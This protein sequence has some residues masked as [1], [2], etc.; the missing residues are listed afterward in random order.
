MSSFMT[1][2]PNQLADVICC[3]Q[4]PDSFRI[5]SGW[6][7]TTRTYSKPIVRSVV[8]TKALKTMLRNND[9]RHNG[10]MNKHEKTKYEYR[11]ITKIVNTLI[12]TRRFVRRSVF[13][14]ACICFVVPGR[15]DFDTS[16]QQFPDSSG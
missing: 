1:F 11:N 8:K 4:V 13:G 2:D 10:K 16:Q 3:E 5:A 9:N 6:R 14:D 12:A 7:W 15:V